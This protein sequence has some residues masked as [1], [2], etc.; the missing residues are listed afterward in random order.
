MLVAVA[1]IGILALSLARV[2]L[3][4][5]A[6][7]FF[8][9]LTY[10]AF[11]F[12]LIQFPISF[13][14]SNGLRF[15]VFILFCG[16]VSLFL[17]LLTVLFF[18]LNRQHSIAYALGITALI[19]SMIVGTGIVKTQRSLP[20]A[21]VPLKEQIPPVF[22]KLSRSKSR[23]QPSIPFKARHKIWPDEAM[24][25]TQCGTLD[26]QIC[27]LLTFTSR[28]PDRFWT[29][30][31]PPADRIGPRRNLSGYQLTND[32]LLFR[33]TD[34]DQSGLDIQGVGQDPL[35]ITS[36]T[37]LLTHSPPSIRISTPIHA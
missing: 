4:K 20:A 27:P 17:L 21:T 16:G 24:I 31:A 23:L 1:L 33:Y 34:D 19:L 3:A 37:N 32:R 12:S 22:R 7:I 30:F 5:A 35:Q 13:G 36:Y 8:V 14:P 2:R 11:V 26:L 15:L 6:L 10:S 9:G 29:L 28:S 25:Q 18:R